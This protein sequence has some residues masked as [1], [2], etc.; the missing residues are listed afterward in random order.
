[1]S[2]RTQR[3]FTIVELLVVITII[4]ILMALLFPAINAAIASARR[5]QC[6]NNQRQVTTAV[7]AT[8][9]AG[10]GIFPKHLKPFTPAGT[11]YWPWTARILP[12]IGRNDIYDAYV[13]APATARTERIDVFMCP[14]DP[15]AAVTEAQ[16]S[17][18]ANAGQPGLNDDISNGIFFQTNDQSL[19]FVAQNDGTATTL[20]LGEN[21]HATTWS[22]NANTE[23]FQTVLWQTGKSGTMATNINL[24]ATTQSN[25]TAIPSSRHAG[26]FVVS[27][28]DNHTRFLSSEI[29]YSVYAL[30]MTPKGSTATNA[31]TA[32]LTESDLK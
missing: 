9:T 29:Q 16:L 1:M 27:F 4:G 24:A 5:G 2:R 19:G 10:S 14:S 3:G 22:S 6:I 12:G 17:F 26:G 20:L 7:I 13:L 18:A 23:D 8:T 15:P 32:I 25:D 31:Q 11:D 28:C 21:V 30:I